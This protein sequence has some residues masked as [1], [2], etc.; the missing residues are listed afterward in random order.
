MIPLL[1]FILISCAMS[2]K[3]L[4]MLFVHSKRYIFACFAA[5]G[6]TLLA[7]SN[8]IRAFSYTERPEKHN[9]T[10]AIIYYIG[11]AFIA[12]SVMI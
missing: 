1:I 5:A 9:I 8:T 10:N 6:A 11:Q 12:L 7:C 4:S 2:A 3:A